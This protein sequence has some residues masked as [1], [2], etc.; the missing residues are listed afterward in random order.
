M[1]SIFSL[2]NAEDLGHFFDQLSS[3]FSTSD[4]EN[5]EITLEANPDDLTKAKIEM[6]RHSPINRLSIGIQSFSAEDLQFMN[7]AH[8]AKEALECLENALAA[9]FE[10]LSIDLIYG[11]PTTSEAQWEENLAT[12]IKLGIPHISSYCL[13]V[14]PQTALAHFV[15]RQ[16]QTSGRRTGRPTVQPP[17]GNDGSSWLRT[18]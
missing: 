9:G 7:R 5:L 4:F 13:T 17:D 1:V 16:I 6:L 18:L 3:H 11:S 12:V 15:K 10:D 8:S 2:L 14:E